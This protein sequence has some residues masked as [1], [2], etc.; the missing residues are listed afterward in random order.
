M[1]ITKRPAKT[2]VTVEDF[3][4]G[5][6]DNNPQ[7]QKGKRVTKQRINVTVDADVLRRMDNLAKETGQSRAALFGLA[8]FKLLETGV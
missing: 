3:I 2:N 7:Q 1:A 4:S 5:A 8:A 6:P